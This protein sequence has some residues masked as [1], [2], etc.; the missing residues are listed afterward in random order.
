MTTA[1]PFPASTESIEVRLQEG[2]F[3]TNVD[4]DFIKVLSG[5]FKTKIKLGTAA[6]QTF[7]LDEKPV[8]IL[9]YVQSLLAYPTD[10]LQALNNLMQSLMMMNTDE[11][12][13]IGSRI[14][15]LNQ[16]EISPDYRANK[17]SYVFISLILKALKENL[18]I[19]HV[20]L[21]ACPFNAD[22]ADKDATQAELLRLERI[23]AKAG[24]VLVKERKIVASNGIEIHY[25]YNN[26]TN[27]TFPS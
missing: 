8:S 7:Q 19:N 27:K 6:I 18:Q 15:L 11:F 13:L 5:A 12:N 25:M 21:E 23:Y 4:I 9:D 14:A 22:I 3:V 20:F 1:N 16:L 2:K 17:L 10:K 26:L 24:F